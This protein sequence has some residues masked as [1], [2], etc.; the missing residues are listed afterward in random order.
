MMNF[1]FVSCWQGHDKP[2][3][4]KSDFVT[5]NFNKK[6][7]ISTQSFQGYTESPDAF[8]IFFFPSENLLK[9]KFKNKSSSTIKFN[10]VNE[11]AQVVSSIIKNSD[12]HDLVDMAIN[13][14]NNDIIK[15]SDEISSK[16]SSES[17]SPE[18]SES[19]CDKMNED[20]INLFTKIDEL[21]QQKSQK[22]FNIQAAI[23]KN[24]T[25]YKNWIEVKDSNAN[26]F[27]WGSDGV[28]TRIYLEGIGQ[29]NSRYDSQRGEITKIKEEHD[30]THQLVN[31]YYFELKEK[32][33]L[34][35]W[36]GNIWKFKLET[37]TFLNKLRL[38]GDVEVFRKGKLIKEGM[39][40]I[41]FPPKEV[42]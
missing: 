22:I 5:L 30:P 18:S 37:S 17:E 39:C 12:D 25:E 33:S 42:L 11:L 8:T 26:R 13:D 27:E 38:K 19:S 2:I 31:V 14:V 23:E 41:D 15:L 1:I 36:N 3:R 32:D 34:G 35:K 7:T 16:C 21:T 6:S 28:P 4:N 40:K 20:L 24:P 9:E 29:F 10:Y